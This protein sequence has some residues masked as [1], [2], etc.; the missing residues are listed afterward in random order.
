MIKKLFQKKAALAAGIA[1][2]ALFLLAAFPLLSRKGKPDFV[3]VVG[4]VESTEVNLSP[5]ISERIVKL[6][7]REGDIVSAGAVAIELDPAEIRA[8]VDQAE[9]NLARG[10]AALLEARANVEKAEASVRDARRSFDR[11]FQLARDGLASQAD[12]DR[13]TTELDLA[14]AGLKAA[15]A[16]AVS[17]RADLR[18]REASL[19]LAKVRLADTVIRSPITGVVTLKAYE[20]GEMV[21]PGMAILTLVDPND[22]WV[23]IDL[24]ET[25]IGKVRLGAPAQ[26]RID[27]LPGKPFAGTLTEVGRVG[28]FATQRD[29][30]RGRQDIKT[31][32]VKVRVPNGGG[33]LKP[34]MTA[35]VRIATGNPP[36][37]S[38]NG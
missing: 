33:I 8:E 26:V 4:I 5:K 11:I 30:T 7:Y 19:A 16:Q 34:G 23:R 13:V 38:A 6:P 35:S 36:P 10:K 25:L 29:V 31:F 9:A 2:V 17:A 12:L 14:Q 28:E 22:L 21:S 32:R 18:Q 27:A 3:E 15:Q 20:V 37:G 1:A 24:E